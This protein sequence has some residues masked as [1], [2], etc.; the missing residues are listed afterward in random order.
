VSFFGTTTRTTTEYVGL[1]QGE[2]EEMVNATGAQSSTY[3]WIT[4]SIGVDGFFARAYIETASK[5][6]S[7]RRVD[8]SGQ[9][10]VTVVETTT[11]VS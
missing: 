11:T 8:A 1:T 6:T 10:H 9:F 3:E 2:A 4:K 5:T 7:A